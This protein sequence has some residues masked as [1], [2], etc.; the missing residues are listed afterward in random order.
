MNA[1]PLNGP[2]HPANPV[3]PPYGHP[4]VQVRNPPDN[5]PNDPAPP[6]IIVSEE[7][8]TRTL[9]NCYN[10]RSKIRIGLGTPHVI[11]PYTVRGITTYT[12]MSRTQWNADRLQFNS[13][14]GIKLHKFTPRNL[15]VYLASSRISYQLTCLR[16]PE[17]QTRMDGCHFGPP[18][19][20]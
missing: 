5:L 9:A 18:R 2:P 7:F 4:V 17:K 10:V 11:R 13:E 14:R 1:A 20:I 12:A 15:S 6:I 19:S 3:A 8:A 16:S